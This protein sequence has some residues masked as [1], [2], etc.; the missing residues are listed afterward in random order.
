MPDANH[1]YLN[2]AHPKDC[3]YLYFGSSGQ[4]LEVDAGLA[5]Q[6]WSFAHPH[7]NGWNSVRARSAPEESLHEKSQSIEE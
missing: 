5:H 1:A 2:P 3:L 6:P 4:G 7:T